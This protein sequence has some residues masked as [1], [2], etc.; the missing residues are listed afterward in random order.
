MEISYG[1]FLYLVPTITNLLIPPGGAFFGKYNF[2]VITIT[3]VSLFSILPIGFF[4]QILPNA[5][6]QTGTG[7]ITGFVFNDTNGNLVRTANEPLVQNWNVK[8][9]KDSTTTTTLTGSGGTYSFTN[10]VQGIYTVSVDLPTPYVS[11]QP[12]N[13]AYQV[14]INPGNTITRNFG[15]FKNSPE[16]LNGFGDIT[17]IMPEGATIDSQGFLY[18]VD[19][20]GN[21]VRKFDTNGNLMLSFGSTG[22]GSGQFQRPAGIVV[23]SLG[24]IFVSD[25]GDRVQKFDPNG[26]FVTQFGSFGTGPGQFNSPRGMAIDAQNNIY[27]ADGNNHRVQKF[28]SNGNYLLTIGKPGVPFSY[29]RLPF[30]VALDSNGNV[31]VADTGNNRI[32]KFDPNGNFISAFGGYGINPGQFN[33]PRD[34]YI[35]SNNFVYVS[36]TYNN[37][38][39]VF[40]NNHVFVRVF[41]TLGADPGEFSNPSG[42]VTDSTNQL[43]VADAGNDRMQ[44][45]DSNGQYL[46]YFRTRDSPIEPYFV[47]FDLLGHL[48]A[49]DGHNHKV[50]TFDAN[51]GELLSEFGKLG[52]DPGEFRGPRGIGVDAT[53]NIYVA[54]NY[55][56][57]V[58]KFDSNGNLLLQWGSTGS[59]TGQFMQPRGVV[60][61]SSGNILVT[62]TLNNRIQRF[63]PNGN[64][65]SSFGS[66]LP[67]GIA[68]DMQGNIYAARNLNNVE[69]YNSNG[70]SLQII[71]AGVLN[72]PTGVAIDSGGNIYVSDGAPSRILKF[73][74][75]GNLLTTLGT[76]GSG[77]S[78]FSDPRGI[79][80]D[81][82]GNLWVDDTG[83]YRIQQFDSNFNFIKQI[84][85]FF[86]GLI[87]PPSVS[88]DSVSNTAPRWGVDAITA[89]GSAAGYS[90]GDTVTV[91][92]GDGTTTT[93]TSISSSGSWGPIT[94][95]YG[96]SAMSTNPNQIIATLIDDNNGEV[97]ATSS[98]SSINVQKHSTILSILISPSSVPVSGTYSV[99]GILMDSTT[100][101]PLSSKTITFRSD[102]PIVISSTVTSASGN[103]QVTGLIAPNT[104]GGY[105]IQA[106]FAGDSLYNLRFSSSPT[107]TVS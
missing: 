82:N 10:L 66:T 81:S 42:L 40:D 72:D 14:T 16:L 75:N 70:N 94:H 11:T 36:D 23:D 6:A 62:D 104:P 55:N 60:I 96:S 41:G 59:G 83:N 50:L 71:G 91:N 15:I 25:R 37:R 43:Y 46:D 4:D 65:L 92:W 69:K 74:P 30:D 93:N 77:P 20:I 101:T 99:S 84:S 2:I 12:L 107:L 86:T 67:Y 1:A 13:N 58:Q 35:G 103:Y 68:L 98:A 24:N 102:P 29:L 52:T 64:F 87:V 105:R 100:N 5:F 45:F 63:G 33:R 79:L 18:D 26:N 54:D 27:V 21:I 53:G 106:Q 31:Y 47:F 76:T 48:L 39:Q 32:Q 61:D 73:A 57:R 89:S 80:I 56:N 51:T 17:G 38:I 78:Q 22:L 85:Y 7:T 97:K 44:Y 90:V 8:L 9:T 19:T 49:S 95:T 28:D 88:I 34:V 3:A